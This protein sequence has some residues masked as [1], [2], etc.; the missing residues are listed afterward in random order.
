MLNQKSTTNVNTTNRLSR[1]TLAGEPLK[2]NYIFLKR[3]QIP[4]GRYLSTLVRVEG[5]KT[6]S[7]AAAIDACYC[8]TAND[9]TEYR[10]RVRMTIKENDFAFQDFCEAMRAC[11]DFKTLADL[12]NVKEEVSIGYNS[13][14]F[15]TI[16]ERCPLSAA[17][18]ELFDLASIPLDCGDVLDDD[19]QDSIAPEDQPLS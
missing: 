4:A 12:V 17:E 3:G 15:A 11:G 7:G 16:Y 9:G 5:A 19:P 13:H 6:N 18:D 14:G 1:A 2:D 8:L 10:M